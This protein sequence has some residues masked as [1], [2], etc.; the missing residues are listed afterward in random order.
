MDENIAREILHELISSLEALETQ[1]GAVL[2]L[3]KD[4]GLAS[5]EELS[6]CL[7]LAAKASDV[8]WRAARV[9]LE[10]LLSTALKPMESDARKHPS[11]PAAARLESNKPSEAAEQKEPA[12]RPEEA[13][14]PASEG[15]SEAEERTAGAE[16]THDRHHENNQQTDES[17]A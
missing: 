3:L 1:S 12:A 11:Q 5:E 6:A 4:K 15:R 7:E 13:R 16:A 8:R 2:Q 14:E 17:A 10:R 9:R